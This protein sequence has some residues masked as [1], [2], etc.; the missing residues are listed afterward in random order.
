MVIV[1]LK[2]FSTI[3]PFQLFA[4]MVSFLWRVLSVHIIWSAAFRHLETECVADVQ[5]LANERG[6]ELR[7]SLGSRLFCLLTDH[8]QF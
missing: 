4:W 1:S 6:D 3:N 2:T 5:L 8:E 7:P